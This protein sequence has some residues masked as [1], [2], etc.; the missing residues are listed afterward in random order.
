MRHG[1]NG[2]KIRENSRRFSK[3]NAKGGNRGQN[4]NNRLNKDKQDTKIYSTRSRKV[5]E[6]E[7]SK[8]PE[9]AE[10]GTRWTLCIPNAQTRKVNIKSIQPETKEKCWGSSD[11]YN[12]REHGL[13]RTESEI[14]GSAEG[15]GR[16]VS[17]PG[18]D[19]IESDARKNEE[20]R[21]ERKKLKMIFWKD[22]M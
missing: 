22:R 12:Q 18:E 7:H 3:R 11:F 2:M 15:V 4:R 20:S 13:V 1:T 14:R 10:K 8:R 17:G 6:A 5:R 19:Q 21:K 9:K 16:M